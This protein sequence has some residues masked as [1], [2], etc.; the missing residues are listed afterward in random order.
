MYVERMEGMQQT[1]LDLWNGNIAPC[2]HCGSHDPVINELTGLIERN[3]ENLSRGLTQAQRE[4]FQKYVDCSDE[5]LLRM[6][7]LA[8]CD[9][10][11]LGTKL[12]IE[13]LL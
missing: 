8:F 11:C 6:L 4:T 7:E 9:G 13:T 5:Y 12:A 10:F 2:E 1:I 3:R